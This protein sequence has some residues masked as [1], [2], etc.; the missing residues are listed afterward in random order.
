M[1]RMRSLK[2]EF[3]ADEELGT[4]ATRDE[5]LLYSGLWGLADEFSRLRGNPVYIRGQIFPYDEDLTDADVDAMLSTLEKLGKLVRYKVGASNYLWLC[6]LAKHQ[7]LDSDKV[8]SRL[9]PPPSERVPDVEDG[10]F[11]DSVREIPALSRLHVAG[12]MEQAAGR[13]REK[14]PLDE[15]TLQVVVEATGATPDE[16]QEIARAV[17][18]SRGPRSLPGLLRT[19]APAGDLGSYLD[20]IRAARV[21]AETAAYLQAARD[22]PECAH[23]KPGGAM[24]HPASGKP[25]C[26]LCRNQA[27]A[28]PQE[29]Q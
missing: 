13:A 21:K 14:P 28:Q 5:R 11:P 2:P 26:V 6:N 20:D 7:R 17:K 8:P 1:A 29:K 12:S 9:P 16:A 18:A 19:M 15:Q 23:L 25:L 3:F 10:N 22:G 27:K 4:L 24:P